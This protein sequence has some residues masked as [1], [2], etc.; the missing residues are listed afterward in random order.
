MSCSSEDYGE[1]KLDC[2]T[3]QVFYQASLENDKCLTRKEK[4]INQLATN[5]Y[6]LATDRNQ[7]TTRKDKLVYLKVSKPKPS[8]QTSFFLCS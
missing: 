1:T 5:S 6:R 2:V 7:L 3:F 4:H 8:L